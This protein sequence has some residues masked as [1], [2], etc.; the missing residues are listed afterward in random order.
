[1]PARAEG[2][3]DV[4]LNQRLQKWADGKATLKDVRN[5]SDEE[6]YSIARMGYFFFYQGK[7][8]EARTIFQGLYAINPVDAYF[9]KALGVIEMASGNTDGA[10]NAYNV[11][12]KISPQDPGAYVGRAEVK[13]V[14]G[15]K[16]QAI[17]DLR[18]A[19]PFIPAGDPLGEKVTAMLQALSRK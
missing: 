10:L 7:L 1:M 4:A 11:V 17:D 5:Y 19:Q 6:L 14:Q 3:T 8:E 15:D 13:L 12:L 18:R 9:A 2:D 16:A